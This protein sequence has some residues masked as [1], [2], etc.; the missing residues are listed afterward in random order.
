M[1]A[2]EIR[3]RLA[4]PQVRVSGP[5]PHIGL[6]LHFLESTRTGVGARSCIGN[7]R[8]RVLASSGTRLICEIAL[9]GH[10]LRS[11]ELEEHLN[12]RIERLRQTKCQHRGRNEDAVLHGVDRLPA[13]TYQLRELRLREIATRSLLAQPA[14]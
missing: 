1:C 11:A 13:D 4:L 3:R 12:G 10:A 14:L 8:T 7:G 9:S 6:R 2:V 5:P